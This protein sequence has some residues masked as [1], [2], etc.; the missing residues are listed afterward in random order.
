MRES[1]QNT[2]CT[3]ASRS[4]GPGGKEPKPLNSPDLSQTELPWDKQCSGARLPIG[5]VPSGASNPQ[6]ARVEPT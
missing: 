2:I 6:V 1:H 5:I 4:Q 3:T